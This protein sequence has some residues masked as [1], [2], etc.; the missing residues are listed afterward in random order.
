[1]TIAIPLEQQAQAVLTTAYNRYRQTQL[2]LPVTAVFDHA[3]EIYV[4]KQLVTA[5]KA[6]AFDEL[7]ADRIVTTGTPVLMQM[8]QQAQRASVMKLNFTGND[9]RWLLGLPRTHQRRRH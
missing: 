6:Y 1:M 9:V 2:N 7:I 4:V 5:A 8:Y 3:D